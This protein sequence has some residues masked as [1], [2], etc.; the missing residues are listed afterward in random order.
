MQRK[1]YFSSV[2]KFFVT[3][4]GAGYFPVAPGTMGAL[5][6]SVIFWF[7]LKGLN[8]FHFFFLT[9]VLIPLSIWLCDLGTKVFNQPDPQKIVLDELVGLFVALVFI[10]AGF[11]TLVM[12]LLLFRFFDIVKLPPCRWIERKFKGGQGVLLDDVVAGI[13]ANLVGQ[14]ILLFFGGFFK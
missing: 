1:Y 4:A 12:Q 3:V 13:Y 2:I 8:P 7:F 14:L 5:F 6:A 11:I 9:I 10:P